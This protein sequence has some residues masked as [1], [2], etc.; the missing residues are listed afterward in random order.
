M[1]GGKLPELRRVSGERYLVPVLAGGCGV[2]PREAA[3]DAESGYQGCGKLETGA[4]DT[5]GLGCD[6]RIYGTGVG[7]K[8]V[9]A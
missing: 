7:E 3:S 8:R 6:R 2:Y 5:G 4:G 9:C 1:G